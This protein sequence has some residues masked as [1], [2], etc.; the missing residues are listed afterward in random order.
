MIKK[1]N[2]GTFRLDKHLVDTNKE[3]W[4]IILMSPNGN[5]TLIGCGIR[6]NKLPKGIWESSYIERKWKSL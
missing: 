4:S 6:S 1:R 3:W 5:P 2:N